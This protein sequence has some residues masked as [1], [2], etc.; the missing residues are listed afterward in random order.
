MLEKDNL[1]ISLKSNFMDFL[2]AMSVQRFNPFDILALTPKSKKGF[3][4]YFCTITIEQHKH[5]SA[6]H[7]MLFQCRIIANNV[8]LSQLGNRM[9]VFAAKALLTTPTDRL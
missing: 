4:V 1:E 7:K 8:S 2:F 9:K 3:D 5:D 6:F